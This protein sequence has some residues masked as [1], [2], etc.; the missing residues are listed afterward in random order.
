MKRK[1][2]VGIWI[3]AAGSL[4]LVFSQWQKLKKLEPVRKILDLINKFVVRL[5]SFM[6]R[7][8]N[9]SMHATENQKDKKAQ[10]QELLE[11]M[12]EAKRVKSCQV[13]SKFFYD[14]ALQ[15][16]YLLGIA[17]VWGRDA[18]SPAEKWA[19]PEVL[20][21]TM[22][23]SILYRV[24][25]AVQKYDIRIVD[26]RV[27]IP[28]SEQLQN[29][30]ADIKMSFEE[31]SEKWTGA[32]IATFI[33]QY[34]ADVAEGQIWLRHKALVEDLGVVLE[35]MFDYDKEGEYDRTKVA[36]MAVQLTEILEK[37]GV[38]AMYY[39]DSRLLAQPKL[40]NGFVRISENQLQYPGLFVR[41]G[42]EYRQLGAFSGTHYEGGK[43]DE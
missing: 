41:D 22:K 19:T 42:A 37:H 7:D 26:G 11:L 40:R 9:G 29:A 18:L 3:A 25:T 38:W 17:R 4:F 34:Q 30:Q 2:G 31:F 27:V 5:Q 12:T 10:Y 28:V 39:H 1:K 15:I 8:E 16:Q 20:K 43:A 36:D 33:R 13:Y 23:N 6:V 24:E 21:S 32:Q 14:I 35:Q